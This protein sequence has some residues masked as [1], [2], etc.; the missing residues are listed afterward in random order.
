M[1][2]RITRRELLRAGSLLMAPALVRGLRAQPA[3]TAASGAAR[4]AGAAPVPQGNRYA[5]VGSYTPNGGGIYLFRVDSATAALTQLQV[6]DDIRNPSWLTLNAAKTR[7]YAVSEIDNYQNTRN[8]AIVSY[9]IDNDSLQIRR[10]GAVSSGG[11]SPA[12]VSMHPSGKFVFAA[13]Y[14]GG[15]VAVFPVQGDG[16]LGDATDLRPSVG[17]RHHGHGVN[18]PPGQFAVSDHDSPHVHMVASDPGGQFVIAND[19]GL[20]L[21]LVWRF[22]AAAGRLL[23]AETPVVAAPPGSAPRHFVFH[24]NGRVL[25]N[26]YEHDAKVAVYDYDP[27]R[28]ALKL[29]QIISSLP[30]KFAGSN[31]ASEI[32]MTADGRYLYAANRLHNA[33]S[34]F[35][36]ADD[37]QL[38]A[39]SEAWVHADSPRSLCLDPGGT[40]LY[41]CNQRGDSITSFRLNANSGALTFTGRFEAVGSPAVMTIFNRP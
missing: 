17:P 23:P 25:Y 11:A 30:P 34:I 19:A 24:R 38:R 3:G 2:P 39:I 13:N 27:A 18:D 12:Y 31:L 36:V 4:P 22:D 40:F 35:G 15:S 1:K 9:A 29:K 28:G 6:I 21:T 41:S 20:D 10:L 16:A 7:L 33:V 5:Y 26:L 8:G 14:G 37:G 32:I